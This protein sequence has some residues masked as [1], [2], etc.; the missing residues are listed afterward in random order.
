MMVYMDENILLKV[1]IFYTSKNIFFNLYITALLST[2][3]STNLLRSKASLK[4]EFPVSQ[5]NSYSPAQLLP[6]PGHEDMGFCV[7]THGRC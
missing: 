7:P 6:T 5:T 4:T 2:T 3:V 1:T